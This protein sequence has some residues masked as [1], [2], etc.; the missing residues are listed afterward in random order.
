MCPILKPLMHINKH[1]LYDL[2]EIHLK[3]IHH[4]INKIK[5]ID[6]LMRLFP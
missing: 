6:Y 4:V 3:Q 1:N 5:C 2:A